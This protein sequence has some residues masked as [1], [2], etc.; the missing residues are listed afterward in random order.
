MFTKLGIAVMF[1]LPEKLRK[2]NFE[3][4]PEKLWLIRCRIRIF[5]SENCKIYNFL[6]SY[7]KSLF[8]IGLDHKTRAVPT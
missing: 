5:K 2:K 8:E 6:M 4:L 3:N 1:S 7:N